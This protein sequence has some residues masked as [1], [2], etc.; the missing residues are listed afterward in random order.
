LIALLQRVSGAH[1]VVGGKTIARIGTGLLVLLGV[2][3]GDG[4]REASRLLDRVLCYRVFPDSEGRMNRSVAEIEAGLLVVPQFTLAADTHKGTRP[5]F[6]RAAVPA[7][8]AEEFERFLALARGRHGQVAQ[9][10]F[11]AHMQVHLVNDG[12]VTF[13]LQVRPGAT[14]TS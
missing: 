8:A 12:P 13:W 10:R 2:E 14:E 3:R 11:G 5:G 4:E 6:S 7:L 9:G 1:V